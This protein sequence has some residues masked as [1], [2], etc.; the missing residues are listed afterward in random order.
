MGYACEGE[1][2]S[3]ANESNCNERIVHEIIHEI[4][5]DEEII[6]ILQMDRED[7]RDLIAMIIE[8]WIKYEEEYFVKK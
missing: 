2:V 1:A 4:S 8:T 5:D 6:K 3:L 7:S